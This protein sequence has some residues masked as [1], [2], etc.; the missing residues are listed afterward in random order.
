MVTSIVK[1]DGREVPYDEQKIFD[2]IDKAV[3]A[4]KSEPRKGRK[5][6]VENAKALVAEKVSAIAD[7]N[8][9]GVEDIQDIVEQ[10]LMEA[11]L[12]H[13]AKAYI[14]YRSERTNKREMDFS[15]MKTLHDLT[16]VD[17]EDFNLK[18]ENGNIDGDTAMG[19]ML[20]YG[21][22]AS[23]TFVDRF[24][25]E[26]D[27]VEA[28]KSGDIHIHDKDFYMLTE[29]CLSA[30]DEVVF[31]YEFDGRIRKLKLKELDEMFD[32]YPNGTVLDSEDVSILSGNKFVNIKNC[33]RHDLGDK[34]MIRITTECGTLDVTSEHR[35]VVWCNNEQLDMHVYDLEE[36]DIM[37]YNEHDLAF[38]NC[39]DLK[40]ELKQ[41]KVLKIEEID[42][43]G[44]V[45]D[46]ETEDNHFNAN[47]FK[48]HNCCQIDLE[49]LLDGGFSTGHGVLREPNGIGAYAALT[50][51]AIQ[52]NQNDQHRRSIA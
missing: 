44:Y 45:Y 29:T 52:A 28:H 7:G 35:V 10:S 23:K 33:V 5:A 12:N 34:T 26:P 40:E 4:T 42:Y 22:E 14:L 51:I 50:A 20:R 19:T 27:M 13:V 25:L 32:E 43:D 3:A 8:K 41:A 2:A 30:E 15:L 16:F 39:D 47:G 36:G 6:K 48:V 18:R 9:V 37:L 1:R 31:R 49:K 17:S 21:S 11:G 24:V 46:F 38:D